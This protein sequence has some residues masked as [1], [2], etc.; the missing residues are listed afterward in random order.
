MGDG[1]RRHR[2][3]RAFVYGLFFDA[4]F[5]RSN[6]LAQLETSTTHISGCGPVGD[7]PRMD[8]REMHK[9]SRASDIGSRI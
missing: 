4:G 2:S 3:F 5:L 6:F 7:S 8:K 1:L 9:R